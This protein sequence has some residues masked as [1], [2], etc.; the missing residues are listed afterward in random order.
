MKKKT[1]KKVKK[2]VGYIGMGLVTAVTMTVVVVIAH[3][4]G[5]ASGHD[6]A[7]NDWFEMDNF[8]NN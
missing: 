2:W 7:T 1:K 5:Y 4:I 6:G 8:F 3:G